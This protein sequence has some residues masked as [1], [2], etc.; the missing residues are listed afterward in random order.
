MLI[1]EVRSLFNVSV[2]VTVRVNR[3]QVRQTEKIMFF[4]LGLT[5]KCA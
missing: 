2:T 1:I 4:T 3:V 5:L